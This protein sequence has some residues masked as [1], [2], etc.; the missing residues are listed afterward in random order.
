MKSAVGIKSIH[1][2]DWSRKSQ[3]LAGVSK[4]DGGERLVTGNQP[5]N[6]SLKLGRLHQKDTIEPFW[7]NLVEYLKKMNKNIS[8]LNKK[9]AS[10]ELDL[11]DYKFSMALHQHQGV[12]VGAIVTFPDPIN[13]GP[14]FL[15]SVAP[16]IIKTTAT[17]VDEYNQVITELKYFGLLI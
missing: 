11:L 7:D 12:G 1:L 2:G 15:G 8:E 13:A 5:A 16:V 17:I 14:E 3:N 4:Y 9:I 10:L 6:P